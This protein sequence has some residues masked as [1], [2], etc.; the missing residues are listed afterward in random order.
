[1]G[2]QLP[3]FPIRSGDSGD[4]SD[5]NR[6]DNHDDGSVGN[7]GDGSKTGAATGAATTA[8]RAGPAATGVEPEAIV[9]TTQKRR[10]DLQGGGYDICAFGHRGKSLQVG[11][12]GERSVMFL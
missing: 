9:T 1:M 8:T 11:E 10:Q 6:D 12:G 2:K 7:H 5:D 4:G 3:Q